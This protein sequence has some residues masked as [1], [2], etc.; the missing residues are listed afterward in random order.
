MTGSEWGDGTSRRRVLELAA[1]VGTLAGTGRLA[2]TQPTEITLEGA[3]SGWVGRTPTAIAGAT[4]P[5]L[6]L[7]PGRTYRVTWANA[8]GV[9]HNFAVLDADGGRLVG[10]GISGEQGASLTLDFEATPAMAEYVCEVHPQSMRGRVAVESGEPQAGAEST[11]DDPTATDAEPTT[12]RGPPPVL[13]ETTIVLGGLV[14]YWLGLAPAGIRGRPNP[15]LRL[16]AGTEYEL[17]WMNLDGLEHDF[18]V[19]GDAGEDLADTS[20]RDDVG[21]THSTSFEATVGMAQYYCEFHPLSMLGAI[22]VV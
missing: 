16:R 20:S 6:T 5:T 10:T 13:E 3:V 21:D 8:D 15:T 12:E 9:P 11:T 7:D 17:V 1:T 22:E 19:R 14:P 18:H 2:T 4:N